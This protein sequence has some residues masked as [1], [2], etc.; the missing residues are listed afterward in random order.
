MI[1]VNAIG[2]TCPVPVVKTRNAIKELG[3]SGGVVETLVDN[4]IAV[5]NLTKMA[6]QKGYS[7]KSEKLE[8]NMFR[9]VMTVGEGTEQPAQ[10]EPEACLVSGLSQRNVVVA[11][12]SDQMGEGAGELGE[13]LLKSFLY[14]LSQQE[15]LPQTVLF[16]NGGARFTCEGS[17]SLED[18]KS[19]EAQGVEILTC[20]TC[21]DFYGL[22]ERLR[23]GEVTNMYV[24]VEKLTGADTLVKP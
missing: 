18:L 8:E 17:G 21:L 7:V 2:D 11:V 13:A 9:V 1:Q 24:I 15:T 20:G 12:G 23:V 22:K 10:E 16:Y 3:T 6:V 4:E 5:Q 14:A 19:L